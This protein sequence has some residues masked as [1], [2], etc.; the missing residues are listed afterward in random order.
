MDS[1]IDV[2][3]F[4]RN[5][6]RITHW[7]RRVEIIDLEIG[8]ETFES[9]CVVEGD[10]GVDVVTWDWRRGGGCRKKATVSVVYIFLNIEVSSRQ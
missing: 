7:V 3:M 9:R 2:S 4:A 5:R 10:L 1:L 6:F 8:S